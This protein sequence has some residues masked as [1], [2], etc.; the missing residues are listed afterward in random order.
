MNGVVVVDKPQNITSH[1]VVT[2]ARRCFGIRRVGHIGTLDPMATGV[3]PLVV[4]QATRLA[5][6]LSV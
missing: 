1:D 6:L 5:S 4:G 3:L 2:R